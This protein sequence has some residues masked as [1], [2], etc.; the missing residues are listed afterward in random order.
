MSTVNLRHPNLPP[1]QVLRVDERRAGA[2]IAAG[3]QIVEPESEPAASNPEQ[4]TDEPTDSAS[5][6][7]GRK[8]TEEQ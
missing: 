5:K 1:E 8:N 2:H 3:W 4:P 6:R 7:R